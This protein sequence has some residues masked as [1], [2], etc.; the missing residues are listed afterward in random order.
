[1]SYKVADEKPLKSD[2]FARIVTSSLK[3]AALCWGFRGGRKWEMQGINRQFAGSSVEGNRDKK[4]LALL[5]Q[6]GTEASR[7]VSICLRR[8][9]QMHAPHEP[10]AD[11]ID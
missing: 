8:A 2:L 4:N 9:A 6:A 10:P 5:L 3:L 11:A 7:S 1:M